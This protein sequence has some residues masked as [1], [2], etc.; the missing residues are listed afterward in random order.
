MAIVPKRKVERA[1]RV[2]T[3]IKPISFAIIGMFIYQVMKGVSMDIPRIDTSDV[4]LLRNVILEPS[5]RSTH[6][7]VLCHSDSGE[8]DAK[9]AKPISSVFLDSY[10]NG[11]FDPNSSVEYLLL[12]CNYEL[13]SSGLS[14][15]QKLN[16]NKKTYPQVFVSSSNLEAPK[17]IPAKYLK[18]GN[19]L[20]TA[21]KKLIVPSAIA[22]S[23][24][25]QLK[26]IC[27]D[28]DFC[29][30]LM[31]SGEVSSGI[32]STMSSLAAEFKNTNTAITHVNADD[33]Y[34]ANLEEIT[35]SIPEYKEGL[36][37]LIAF[38]KLGGSAK[39]IENSTEKSGRLKTS[40][41]IFKGNAEDLEAVNSYVTGIISGSIPTT[42]VSALP[43]IKTRTKKSQKTILA[44]REKLVQRAKERSQKSKLEQETSSSSTSK[45][46]AKR[47]RKAERDRRRREHNAANN[48]KEKTPEQIREM[49][50]NRRRRMEEEA[51]KWNMMDSDLDDLANE[52]DESSSSSSGD[53]YSSFEEF[54]GEEEWVDVDEDDDDGEIMD[55]D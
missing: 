24:T 3:L 38:K 21:I 13:P 52:D 49:E 17:Q 54:D 19:M 4:E 30:L 25:A 18:T 15:Y 37:R 23:K 12:D 44:K 26:N 31:K 10:A 33:F 11:G 7:V 36:Q 46:D 45:E 8:E 32:K 34:L 50:A 53:S 41:S 55:L 43:T 29:F 42:K 47:D 51:A 35:L 20:T 6:Y 48:V 27:L 5:S 28:N 39:V 2:D 40:I 1:P 14:V 16:L 9:S 22:L